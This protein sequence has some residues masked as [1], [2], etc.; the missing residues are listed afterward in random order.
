MKALAHRGRQLE[1]ATGDGR[2]SFDLVD[3]Y[4]NENQLFGVDARARAAIASGGL[5]EALGTFFEQRTFIPPSIDRVVPLADGR[6]AHAAVD[7][8]QVGGALCWRLKRLHRRSAL[9]Q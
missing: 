2:I 8:G 5:L 3:F 6:A 7:R 9:A 4:H 1:I